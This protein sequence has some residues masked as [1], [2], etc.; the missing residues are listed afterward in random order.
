MPPKS[1]RGKQ[2]QESLIK[3]RRRLQ[4]RNQPLEESAS[5]MNLSME[6]TNDLEMADLLRT[7]DTSLEELDTV[8]K[9]VDAS[10]SID[11]SIKSDV[12]YVIDT[13]CEIGWGNLSEIIWY[14]LVFL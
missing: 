13:F 7:P 8:D 11:S 12:D 10:F 2:C 14:P 9:E 5:S 3:V 6:T 1:K 4:E